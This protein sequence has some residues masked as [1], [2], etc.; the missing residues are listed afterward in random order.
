MLKAFCLQEV[1]SM[2]KCSRSQGVNIHEQMQ[3]TI[4]QSFAFFNMVTN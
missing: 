3:T 2:F 1:I 4:N